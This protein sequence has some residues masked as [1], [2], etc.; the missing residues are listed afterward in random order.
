MLSKQ[1]FTTTLALVLVTLAWGQKPHFKDKKVASNIQSHISY[2]TSEELAGRYV[3]TAGEKMSADYIALQFEEIGLTPDGDDG[4]LQ[5]IPIPNLRMAQA[6]STLTLGDDVLTLFTDYYPITI[7]A[8]NGNHIGE[9]INIGYGVEDAGLKHNDYK[10]K[11]ITNKAV[12]INLDIPGGTNQHN[13]FMSWEGA[14]MRAQYAIAKGARAV[15]FHTTNEDLVPGGTLE[16]TLEHLGKPILFVKRDLGKKD[17]NEIELNLQVMLLTVNAHNVVGKIDNNAQHTVI[18]A[19]HHD[20]IGV[21]NANKVL[22]EYKNQIH[23]GADNNASGVAALIE[24]AKAIKAKPKKYA[25]HNYIFVALTGAEENFMGSKYFVNSK[26]YGTIEPS[27]MLNLDMIGHLD[28]TAKE[29]TLKGAGTSPS[30]TTAISNTRIC[31]RKIQT[32]NTTYLAPKESDATFFYMRGA[33]GL[34]IT[35]GIQD[36]TNTP[37][38]IASVINYGGEAFIVRYV[39]KLIRTLDKEE[40]LQITKTVTERDLSSNLTVSFGVVPNLA[41][42]ADGILVGDTEANSI[43]QKAG[44]LPGDIIIQVGDSLTTDLQ[45][46]TNSLTSLQ[47]GDTTSVTIIRGKETKTL[48]L[49]F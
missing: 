43:A 34:H 5:Y 49:Q 3:A 2:L 27:Y 36:Y 18:L 42:K 38:D 15:L 22:A 6:N 16:K 35:T 12:I 37:S 45:A 23:Y 9:A 19:A 13:R 8:N 32:I 39:N 20:H 47:A 33:P 24:L 11:D 28:S 31:K 7:S 44:I 21:G 41:Y 10:G 46:Y 40:R 48:P 29:L 26:S 25:N 17:I 14:E 4:Y 1:G 30:W